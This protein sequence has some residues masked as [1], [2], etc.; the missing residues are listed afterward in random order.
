EG[1][2]LIDREAAERVLV[3]LCSW[4]SML[5]EFCFELNPI[6]VYERLSEEGCRFDYVPLIY[7]YVTYARGRRHT[8]LDFGDIPQVGGSTL[9]GTGIAVSA[10]SPH[11]DAAT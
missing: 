5:P 2:K 4:G 7:G 11:R 1:E 9:G 3:R 6:G 10:R 8:K